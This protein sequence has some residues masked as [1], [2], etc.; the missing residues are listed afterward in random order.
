M[1]EERIQ[2]TDESVP[3]PH[4]P[5]WYVTRTVEGQSYPV[6][7]R[8]RTIAWSTPTRATSTAISRTTSGSSATTTATR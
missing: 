2:E 6:F 7:C 8:G 3:V 1:A 5:W 4:G